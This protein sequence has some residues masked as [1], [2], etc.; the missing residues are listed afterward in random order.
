M[1]PFGEDSNLGIEGDEETRP[2]VCRVHGALRSLEFR[3]ITVNPCADF[4]PPRLV[5]SLG[6]QTV[7]FSG[8]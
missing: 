1:M 6:K 7:K 3:S 2:E 5:G 4:F 8:Y